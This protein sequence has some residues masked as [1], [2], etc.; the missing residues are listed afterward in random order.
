[1]FSLD[2]TESAI[3]PQKFFILCADGDKLEGTEFT[4]SG[5]AT[6]EG[7]APEPPLRSVEKSNDHA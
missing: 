6:A 7:E 4:F 3:D 2:V 5:Q 1:M